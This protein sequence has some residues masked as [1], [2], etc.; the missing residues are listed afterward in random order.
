[1]NRPRPRGI[2]FLPQGVYNNSIPV[3]MYDMLS[4][5]EKSRFRRLDLQKMFFIQKDPELTNT[6]PFVQIG[7][8][9]NIPVSLADMSRQLK[10]RLE[11]SE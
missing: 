8:N 5:Y 3:F 6:N 7:I 11:E 10:E 2:H 4:I 9:A 1:M